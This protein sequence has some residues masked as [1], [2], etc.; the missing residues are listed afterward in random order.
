MSFGENTDNEMCFNFVNYY[1]KGAL[2]CG[3]FGAISAGGGLPGV[4]P[5]RR[6]ARRPRTPG[7]PATR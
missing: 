6:P 1:P 5:G 7:T 2:N 4:F 3:P